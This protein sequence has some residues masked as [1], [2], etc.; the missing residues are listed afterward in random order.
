MTR[1]LCLHG[2]SIAHPETFAADVAKR[3]KLTLKQG[4]LKEKE[5]GENLT[6][7]YRRGKL[8][9]DTF[10]PYKVRTMEGILLADSH[11]SDLMDVEFR[12]KRG[13]EKAVLAAVRKLL[14]GPDSFVVADP[15]ILLRL[16]A[17]Q[18]KPYPPMDGDAGRL[19]AMRQYLSWQVFAI[20]Q[21]WHLLYKDPANKLL[22]RQ[23][24][25]RIRRLRSCF[26][27]FR[28]GLPETETSRWQDMF[29]EEADRLSTM[30]ELDVAAQMCQR[31]RDAEGETNDVPSPLL[32]H[33][34]QLREDE[35]KKVLPGDSLNNHTEKLAEFLLWMDGMEDIV[36]KGIAGEPAR[37]F[38]D[39]RLGEWADGLLALKQK[40]PD[41]SN[42]DDLH[43]IRIKVKRFRY[44][45]Q[46]IDL[47]RLPLSLL[48]QLKQLQDVLGLLHDDYVNASWAGGIALKH[49][50]DETLQKQVH[51]FRNWQSARSESALAMVSG[52]WENFLQMLEENLKKN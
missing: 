32:D 1:K 2:V 33:F 14:S 38:V 31:R 24:R 27:F 17:M 43:K 25:V 50:E 21:H 28:E 36:P 19:R 6:A 30:R 3:L 37:Q 48:R 35:E 7:R 40:Y 9:R 46:T 8:V 44:V 26:V 47:A 16:N 52:M 11:L 45:T 42:M 12:Y 23:L 22:V 49:P 10:L 13:S 39:R 29:R 15:D 18:G 20:G 41:F 4:K 51:S 34:L 5:Y